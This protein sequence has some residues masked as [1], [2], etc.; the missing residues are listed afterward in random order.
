MH[1]L[2]DQKGALIS[3]CRSDQTSA[4]AWIQT[5]RKY[6]GAF[7]HY[8]TK[9]LEDNNWSMTYEDL[10]VEANALLDHHGYN[11]R[12]ELNCPS[13]YKNKKFLESF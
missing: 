13:I 9:A 8:F 10:A 5:E 1:T 7:S 12:P 2:E 6:M 3:G 4:D 11:Q